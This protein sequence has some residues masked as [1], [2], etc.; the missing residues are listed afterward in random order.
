V[1]A[2]TLNQQQLDPN[3]YG[4]RMVPVYPSRRRSSTNVSDARQQ[5]TLKIHLLAVSG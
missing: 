1:F 5:R 4:T 2:R 3:F